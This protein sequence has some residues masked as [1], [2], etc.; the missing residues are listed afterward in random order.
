MEF[1]TPK[2]W[3]AAAQLLQLPDLQLVGGALL[4]WIGIKLIAEDVGD[5]HEIEANARR[6]SA[7]KP[8]IGTHAPGLHHVAPALGAVVVVMAGIWRTRRNRSAAAH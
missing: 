4:V 2:F 6:V 3:I 7:V 8:R 5:E 1:V